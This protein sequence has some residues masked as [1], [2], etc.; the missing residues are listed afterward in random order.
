MG[1]DCLL[2]S[3]SARWPGNGRTRIGRQGRGMHGRD[4]HKGE[5][6][7]VTLIFSRIHATMCPKLSVVASNYRSSHKSTPGQELNHQT[8]F[9][10]PEFRDFAPQSCADP[11]SGV[12]RRSSHCC[13]SH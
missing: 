7:V 4:F 10:A 8:A 3:F 9:F 12:G 11:E 1:D 6:C 2:G 13:D 5:V